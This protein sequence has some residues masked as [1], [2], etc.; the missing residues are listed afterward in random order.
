LYARPPILIE[1]VIVSYLSHSKL[2][3]AIVAQFC[4]SGLRIWV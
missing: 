2:N 3:I 1:V 4:M